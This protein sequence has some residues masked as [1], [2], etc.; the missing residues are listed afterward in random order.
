MDGKCGTRHHSEAPTYLDSGAAK[1]RCRWGQGPCGPPPASGRVWP[2]VELEGTRV[3][4]PR[5]GA[6]RR[7]RGTRSPADGGRGG[8]SGPPGGPVSDNLCGGVRGTPPRVETAKQAVERRRVSKPRPAAHAALNYQDQRHDPSCLVPYAPHP[9]HPSLP[10]PPSH[11][12]PLS[13]T[14]PVTHPYPR[15]SPPPPPLTARDFGCTIFVVPLHNHLTAWGR[16]PWFIDR[17]VDVY[18]GP[19]SPGYR[20]L[21]DVLPTAAADGAEPRHGVRPVAGDVAGTLSILG[22]TAVGGA[23]PFYL[24]LF[25]SF[26]VWLLFCSLD[27][28]CLL[29]LPPSGGVP[30]PRAVP[31]QPLHSPTPSQHTSCDYCPSWSLGLLPRLLPPDASLR[32]ALALAPSP[33]SFAPWL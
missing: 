27:R 18:F 19:P 33:P 31:G 12:P 3:A 28:H 32:R 17:P 21:P 11:P 25:H 9:T 5:S 26:A 10:I 20:R 6:Y 13:H 29:V 22:V 8:C 7:E 23:C 15:P 30:L 14:P 16:L 24:V 1:R 4:R 2:G